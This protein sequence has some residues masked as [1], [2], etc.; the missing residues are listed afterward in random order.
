MSTY[1]S[2]LA[3]FDYL[4]LCFNNFLLKFLLILLKIA[5]VR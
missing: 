1:Y 5:R 2:F 4:G 3:Y